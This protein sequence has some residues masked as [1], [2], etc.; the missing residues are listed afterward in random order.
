MI[1]RR[2]DETRLLEDEL[3]E[4]VLVRQNEEELRK[5]K[6][7]GEKMKKKVEQIKKKGVGFVFPFAQ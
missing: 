4:K 5:S 6:E 7:E 3:E 1:M 2:Y